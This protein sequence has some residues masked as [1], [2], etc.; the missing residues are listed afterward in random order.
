V[1]WEEEPSKSGAG[2]WHEAREEWRNF[3]IGRYQAHL[4]LDGQAW[5]GAAPAAINFSV[6]PWHLLL[7]IFVAL[8]V[9][10]FL[11]RWYRRMVLLQVR[12]E[13][14]KARSS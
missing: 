1:I 14:S 9:I 11:L 13:K 4:V 10:I 8:V 3:A 5:V 2:F 6:W 7:V 12:S